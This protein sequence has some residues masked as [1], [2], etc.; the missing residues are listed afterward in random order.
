MCVRSTPTGSIP[1]VVG[2][3]PCHPWRTSESG[4]YDT[5]PS[6]NSVT[7]ARLGDTSRRVGHIP[8][9]TLE[10]RS[11]R[12][13]R[14]QATGCCARP[15]E[16]LEELLGRLDPLG[17]GQP[18]AFV[19][20]ADEAVVA[21]VGDDLQ[22]PGIVERGLAAAGRRSRSSWRRPPWRTASSGRSRRRRRSCTSLAGPW[23]SCR[24]RG[25][26]PN[27]S[28]PTQEIRASRASGLLDGPPWFSQMTLIPCFSA[29]KHAQRE[30]VEH[31]V[32]L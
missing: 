25:S 26:V 9:R 17:L 19:L 18:L 6:A 2:S 16:R 31:G 8:G 13:V 30:T 24:S 10:P 22:D 28:L 27:R 32:L 12:L 20:D 11:L 3:G 23:G 1:R 15:A 21:A 7:C 5:A 29:E 4:A 14:D